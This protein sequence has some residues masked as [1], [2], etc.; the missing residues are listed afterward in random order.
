MKRNFR[1]S[2][3]ISFNSV[4]ELTCR[5]QEAQ[6]VKETNDFFH[7]ASSR[8][9]TRSGLPNQLPESEDVNDDMGFGNL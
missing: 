6:A 3:F 7:E 5:L 4:K 1:G 2:P 8:Y 9:D